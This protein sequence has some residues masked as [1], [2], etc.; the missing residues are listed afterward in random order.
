[1]PVIAEKRLIPNHQFGFRSK[2]ATVE[3]SYK[4]NYFSLCGGEALQCFLM[5]RRLLIRYDIILFKIQQHLSKKFHAILY[6]SYFSETY[7]FFKQH[8]VITEIREIQSGVPQRS[9]L[10]LVLYLL[11]C[12]FISRRKC[13]YCYIRG[14]S[15]ICNKDLKT[16]SKYFQNKPHTKPHTKF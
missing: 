1:M 10:G 8:D 3:Q 6:K 4:Q 13:F 7:F 11:H 5:F 14:D 9:I 2:H 15:S 12:A 16:A